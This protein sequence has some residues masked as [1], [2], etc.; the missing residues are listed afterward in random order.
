VV[1]L[2]TNWNA[3]EFP[4]I[5]WDLPLVAGDDASYGYLKRRVPRRARAGKNKGNKGKDRGRG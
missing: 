5:K 3:A 4:M 1:K 2:D